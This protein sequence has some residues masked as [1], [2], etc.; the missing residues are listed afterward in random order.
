MR[1]ITPTNSTR[2]PGSVRNA[3]LNPGSSPRISLRSDL[4]VSTISDASGKLNGL[5]PGRAKTVSSVRNCAW[6]NLAKLSGPS[7]F[8]GCERIGASGQSRAAI[9][10]GS[11]MNGPR[12]GSGDEFDE[13]PSAAE[14]D[15]PKR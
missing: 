14:A 5:M 15:N 13:F 8:T 6:I 9:T 3:E 7:H 4:I 1:L 10:S 2:E 11:E 12:R